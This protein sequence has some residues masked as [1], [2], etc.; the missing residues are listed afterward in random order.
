MIIA[1]PSLQ[2][3]DHGNTTIIRPAGSLRAIIA[4][5]LPRIPSASRPSRCCRPGVYRSR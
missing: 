5:A 1:T 3:H 2:H 4:A